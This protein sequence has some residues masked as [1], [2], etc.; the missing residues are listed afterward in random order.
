MMVE[1]LD[2]LDDRLD[3]PILDDIGEERVIVLL[4]LWCW[5]VRPTSRLLNGKF[6]MDIFTRRAGWFKMLLP[7][8]TIRKGPIHI[9]HNEWS[10]I[11]ASILPVHKAVPKGHSFNDS[12]SNPLI[13]SPVPTNT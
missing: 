13:P 12:P 4:E 9:H 1:M 8:R 6:M 11:E 10:W 5:H 2:E 7:V 3:W